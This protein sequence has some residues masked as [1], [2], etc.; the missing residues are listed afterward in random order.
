M[1]FL[2]IYRAAET[3]TPPTTEHM[4]AM[5]KLIQ[6]M[7]EKGI[8]IATE[9]CLPTKLGARVR[10]SNGKITVTDGPF[11]ES[12][13]VV[14]GFALVR[15]DSKEEAIEWTKKFLEVAGDGESEVRQIYEPADFGDTIPADLKEQDKRSRARMAG[16][17]AR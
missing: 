14:G 8:L 11:T 7:S 10:R 17:S 6:E 16:Y 15:C 5:G 3:E 2:A 9:G 1:K 13:E 12:K 4:A